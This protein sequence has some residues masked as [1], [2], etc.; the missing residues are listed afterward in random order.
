MRAVLLLLLTCYQKKIKIRQQKYLCH[1][2]F[3]VVGLRLAIKERKKLVGMQVGVV[4]FGF[5]IVSRVLSVFVA[6]A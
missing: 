6:N 5:L 4:C 3:S 1:K 2:L